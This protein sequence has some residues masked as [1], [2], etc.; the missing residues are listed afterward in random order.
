MFSMKLFEYL[1]AVILMVAT[2]IHRLKDFPCLACFPVSDDVYS[3]EQSIREALM[4]SPVERQCRE[5]VAAQY[6]YRQRSL[7]MSAHL[8]RAVVT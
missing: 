2:S 1:A 6:T 8:P 5:L 7:R 4:V 3:W